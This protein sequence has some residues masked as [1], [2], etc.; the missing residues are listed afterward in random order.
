[1]LDDLVHIQSQEEPANARSENEQHDKTKVEILTCSGR[2]E[3]V[4][5]GDAI[6][7]SGIGIADQGTH[8][9]NTDA[10]QEEGEQVHDPG[11][12]KGHDVVWHTSEEEDHK[13]NARTRFSLVKQGGKADG[14]GHDGEGHDKDGDSENDEGG[15]LKDD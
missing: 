5:E 8:Y 2:V 14:L 7:A 6:V 15:L 4:G 12:N 9:S 13:D 3:H 1:M 11:R 10:R